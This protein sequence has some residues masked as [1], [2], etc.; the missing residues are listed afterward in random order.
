MRRLAALG[1]TDRPRLVEPLLLYAVSINR[2]D[3][4]MSLVW[5]ESVRR[6]YNS[7]LA[8]LGDTDL[9]SVAMNDELPAGLPREYGKFLASYKAYRE[10]P[11]VEERA[12]SLRRQ[13]ALSMKIMLGVSA[14]SIARGVGIDY[15][16]FNAWLK[17]DDPNRISAENAARVVRYL[18]QQVQSRASLNNARI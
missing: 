4:L 13:E 2:V 7:V 10:L 17:N 8:I 12:K 11:V 1:Q 3:R 6:S 16:N 9:E 15:G 5:K 18:R 14:V